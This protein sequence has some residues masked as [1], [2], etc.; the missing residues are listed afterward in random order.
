MKFPLKLPAAAVAILF[1]VVMAACGQAEAAS[2]TEMTVYL[3]PTCGCCIGWVD[4]MRAN[5]FTVD[6]I[7]QDDLT[8]VRQEHKVP[9]PLTSC[10]LGIVEGFAIEGHVPADVV[11]RL[12]RDRP[13]VLGVA[14]PGM[15]A[16]TPGMEQPDGH[17]DAYDV[18][19]FDE[20]GPVGVYE[21]RR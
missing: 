7:Y 9:V 5:G 19:S 2:K 15:V 11:Q 14:V 17:V 13:A 8:A 20:S 3:T 18:Y 16:G 21:S 12:L 6:V 1:G 10:H 4:H